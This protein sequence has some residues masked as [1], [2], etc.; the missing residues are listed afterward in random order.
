MAGGDEK[1]EG[2][3]LSQL[4]QRAR[5]SGASQASLDALMDS[6]DPRAAVLELVRQR[7]GRT[8]VP[9]LFDATRVGETPVPPDGW[10]AP[11][12]AEG[13]AAFP[14]VLSDQ[15]CEHLLEE[16][17]RHSADARLGPVSEA[18]LE[19]SFVQTLVSGLLGEQ[20]D[21]CHSTCDDRA[22]VAAFLPPCE[23]EA[24][25]SATASNTMLQQE[26]W[27]PQGIAPWCEAAF[28]HAMAYLRIVFLPSGCPREAGLCLVPG[29]HLVSA[30]RLAAEL[31]QVLGGPAT[32]D[33][34]SN[35]QALLRSKYRLAARD[36]YLPPKT[37]VAI[38]GRTWRGISSEA[39]V[40][41]AIAVTPGLGIA[42][43]LPSPPHPSTCATTAEWS[44]ESVQADVDPYRRMLFARR[45]YADVRARSRETPRL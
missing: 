37:I 13:Y 9:P 39:P 21:F 14:G 17:S 3:R 31:Q 15:A 18:L 10:V 26:H 5:D 34:N 40:S 1:L 19:C 33:G 22:P 32:A 30:P 27:Q 20:Y 25:T 29:S 36:L 35:V 4:L 16:L 7:A 43:K 2:L 41:T 42:F 44:I 6:A 23:L 38:D 8:R 24:G 45:A 28:S 11:F 12:A